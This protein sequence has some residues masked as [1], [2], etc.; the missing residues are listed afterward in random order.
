VESQVRK[1]NPAADA[2]FKK[3]YLNTQKLEGV[4]TGNYLREDYICKSMP[5]S[6]DKGDNQDAEGRWYPSLP[7]YM[8]WADGGTQQSQQAWLPAPKKSNVSLRIIL[9][10]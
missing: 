5:S 1:T 9:R 6:R 2:Y 3:L 4:R 10:L 7:A 8:M